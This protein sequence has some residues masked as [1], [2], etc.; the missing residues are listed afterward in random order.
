MIGSLLESNVLLTSSTLHSVGGTPGF[1]NKAL[2]SE[3]TWRQ[4][5]DSKNQRA[6]SLWHVVVLP[7][8][9][10]SNAPRFNFYYGDSPV[11]HDY[12]VATDLRPTQQN[13]L[14]GQPAVFFKP[15]H[16]TN[17]RTMLSQQN[18]GTY[19]Q[20][21]P[22]QNYS[23][24]GYGRGGPSVAPSQ[25]SRFTTP[26]PG[27][28]RSGGGSTMAFPQQQFYSQT[29]QQGSFQGFDPNN[30][31]AQGN[32]QGQGNNMMFNQSSG[33]PMDLLPQVHLPI[34]DNYGYIVGEG[35]NMNDGNMY[36][37]NVHGSNMYRSNTYSNNMVGP[38][39][40]VPFQGPQQQMYPNQQSQNA[41][42]SNPQL[43]AAA[44]S[45]LS[46][47]EHKMDQDE[48]HQDDSDQGDSDQGDSDQDEGGE[49]E[50]V[51]EVT[52]AELD[53][54]QRDQDEG[55]ALGNTSSNNPD[56]TNAQP[57]DIRKPAPI[58]KPDVMKNR[59]ASAK[60][61]HR[62]ADNTGTNLCDY[63]GR[64]GH[65]A[66]DCIKWDPVHFDKPVC[67]ACNNDQHS[68]DEC[69]KFRAMTEHQRHALLL[70]KG[71]RRPGVR[72]DYHAWTSYVHFDFIYNKE[73]SGGFPL[74]RLF[75]RSLSLDKD[76]GAM[77]QNLWKVWDYERG[78]PD[79][80]LDPR[81]GSL[82][83]L[84]ARDL[85]ESFKG[86]EH[87]LGWRMPVPRSV[88]RAAPNQGP[89]QQPHRRQCRGRNGGGGEGDEEEL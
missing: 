77:L 35:R 30:R 41:E 3:L 70:G 63:C 19:Q 67:T 59:L 49:N 33:T 68:L 44:Q 89:R 64:D 54:D 47:V 24:G 14:D 69:A 88:S 72:S 76:N 75:L 42:T 15:S 1:I 55:V 78:V 50:A 60:E 23:L 62:F 48:D 43:A 7:D 37:G 20:P 45:F 2:T 86:G 46:F 83:S 31:P 53:Q 36:D 74:T 4:L 28:F 82:T 87:K 21:I 26:M 66:A 84:P 56:G 71:G 5:Q 12:P 27:S 40:P 32:Y 39:Q 13:P 57:A 16:Q 10:I 85:D 25:E 18:P 51:Q 22:T 61:P 17:Q 8:S 52:Q 65:E 58:L 11:T 73:G 79:Q 80:F 9:N 81:A 38:A 6:E 29:P 34:F